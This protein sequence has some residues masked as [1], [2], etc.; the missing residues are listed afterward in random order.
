MAEITTQQLAELLI[1]IARSQQAVVDAIEI[2][3]PGFKMKYFSP[4]LQSAAKLR[5]MDYTATLQDLPARVLLQCQSRT[6]P[7]LAQ[8]AQDLEA[9][10]AEKK[11]PIAP[12]SIPPA[13]ARAASQS[14]AAAPAAPPAVAAPGDA[15]PFETTK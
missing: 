2:A 14:D 8:V 3:Q 13:L 5:N 10:L 15:I 6:G 9:M 1:G 7:D 4:V 11:P 12:T